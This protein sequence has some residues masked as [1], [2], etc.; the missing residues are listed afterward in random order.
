MLGVGSEVPEFEHRAHAK[1]AITRMVALMRAGAMGSWNA[2]Q[3]FLERR[4]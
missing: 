4:R 3:V 1:L 2:D